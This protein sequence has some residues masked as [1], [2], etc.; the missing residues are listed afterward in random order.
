ML[1]KEIESRCLYSKLNDLMQIDTKQM[2]SQLEIY[3]KSKGFEISDDQL[4]AWDTTLRF[5]KTHLANQ[6]QEI[7]VIFEYFLAMEGGRR[8]DVILLV[9]DKVIILEFKCKARY[10]Y[11]DIHQVIGYRRDIK[12]FHYITSKNNLTVEA[13]LVLTEE[14]DQRKNIMGVEV[15]TPST[16]NRIFG[17]SY[18]VLGP[19]VVEAWIRSKYQPLPSIIN[20]TLQLFKDGELP[21]IKSIAD[22]DIM[23][24]VKLVKKLINNNRVKHHKK[25]IIFVTGVPGAGKTLVALKAL[26]D[27]NRYCYEKHNEPL[28]ALYLSGNGPLVNVLVKQLEKV[29]VNDSVGKTYVRDMYAFKREFF[30][31]NRIPEAK[32]LFFDEAQRAWDE[33]KTGKGLSEPEILM[34]IGNKIYDKY[35]SITLVCFIGEGQAIHEGEE[36]GMELW[37]RALKN[38]PDWIINYPPG[39]TNA[40]S[41]IT[42]QRMMM[43]KELHLSTS[44]RNN[45]INI[46]P[47]VEKVLEGSTEA[48]EFLKSLLCAGYRIHVHR[49]INNCK[50]I[51]LQSLSENKD[52]SYG[53]I[54]SSKVSGDKMKKELNCANFTSF[55][56]RNKAGK[57]FL[58]DS[59]KFKSAA[60]EFLCQGLELDLPILIFGGDYYIDKGKWVICDEVKKKHSAKFEDLNVILNNIYRVLLTRSRKELVIF[61]PQEAR[62]DETYNYFNN[63]NKMARGEIDD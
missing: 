54:I 16:F 26:Y 11:E 48:V 41:S 30:N 46:A 44:I 47:F 52:L 18:E 49:D 22:G 13:Y 10:T 50:E 29:N 5:L 25:R 24:S 56:D 15:L 35:K 45:F 40:M 59:K 23:A 55:I 57:W 51:V 63:V 17:S 1:L 53:Y 42:A 32:V 38:N 58:T 27:Y 2:T 62:M 6:N 34:S 3:L 61:I 21:Y 31:N 19:E 37:N 12:N 39:L 9:K 60:S 20:A 33:K 36:G 14:T 28:A 8:P 7:A 4:Y 43:N